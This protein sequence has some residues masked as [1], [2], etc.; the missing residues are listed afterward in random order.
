MYKMC[1]NLSVFE[2]YTIAQSTGYIDRNADRNDN[3]Q[4]CSQLPTRQD[5]YGNKRKN[6]HIKRIKCA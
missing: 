5:K 6:V 4:K 2:M 1:I 3:R